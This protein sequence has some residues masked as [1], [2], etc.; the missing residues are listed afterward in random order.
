LEN[1]FNYFL[2][3]SEKKILQKRIRKCKKIVGQPLLTVSYKKPLKKFVHW[4][5]LMI[6]YKKPLGKF[7]ALGFANGFL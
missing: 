1:K 5:L 3:V 2:T 7:F 6:S 4:V